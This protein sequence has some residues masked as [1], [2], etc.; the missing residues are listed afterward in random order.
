[1]SC[2]QTDVPCSRLGSQPPIKTARHLRLAVAQGGTPTPQR[3]GR[4]KAAA[5]RRG[6]GLISASG[7]RCCPPAKTRAILSRCTSPSGNCGRS[8]R[9][10]YPL[11]NGGIAIV[12][13]IQRLTV[14][15]RARQGGG[16]PPNAR[17]VT[18]GEIWLRRIAYS[19]V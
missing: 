18:E 10:L 11:A 4:Q 19:Y 17:F 16:Q 9:R 2:Y 8:S 6:L 5:A 15:S 3:A 14:G 12:S 1:M 7:K 13:C